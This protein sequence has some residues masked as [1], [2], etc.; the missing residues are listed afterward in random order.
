MMKATVVMRKIMMP[1][2]TCVSL[3]IGKA[4]QKIAQSKP[5]TITAIDFVNFEPPL[6]M[7][8]RLRSP[9]KTIAMPA[10]TNQSVSVFMCKGKAKLTCT[11][12]NR[13]MI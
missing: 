7:A 3:R 12:P 11:I 10:P 2:Y 13:I 5:F 6:S 1:T 9:A 8:T 4:K